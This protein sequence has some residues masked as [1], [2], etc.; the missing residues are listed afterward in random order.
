MWKKGWVPKTA[1]FNK[2]QRATPRF[3]GL[4]HTCRKANEERQRTGLCLAIQR[5]FTASKEVHRQTQKKVEGIGLNMGGE[6]GGS[7]DQWEQGKVVQGEVSKL[8]E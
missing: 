8:G 6:R 7:E 1:H 5:L 3:Q 2:S 4:E